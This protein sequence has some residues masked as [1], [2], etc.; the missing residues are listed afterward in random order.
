MRNVY[1]KGAAGGVPVNLGGTVPGCCQSLS[2][3]DTLAGRL[4]LQ[5]KPSSDLTLRLVGCLLYTS[6]CV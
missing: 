1:P 5:F 3:D 2:N 4:Q 6:R